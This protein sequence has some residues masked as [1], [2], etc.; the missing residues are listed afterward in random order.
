[1]RA[2]HHGTGLAD[3]LLTVAIASGPAFLWVFADNP[4]A[5]RFYARHRFVPDGAEMIDADTGLPEIRMVR[6]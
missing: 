6:G 3:R 5:Q 4:R 1:M 2:S